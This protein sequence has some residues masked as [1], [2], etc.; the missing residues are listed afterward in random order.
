ME[1]KFAGGVSQTGPIGYLSWVTGHL[2]SVGL[3]LLQRYLFKSLHSI[4]VSVLRKL[5]WGGGR[6]LLHEQHNLGYCKLYLKFMVL[7]Q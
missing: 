5:S 2:D 3:V 7:D 1:T 6:I 4:F